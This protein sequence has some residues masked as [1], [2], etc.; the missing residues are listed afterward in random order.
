[1]YHLPNIC[2]FVPSY[3]E[4]ATSH[5]TAMLLAMTVIVDARMHTSFYSYK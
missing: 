5:R 3:R 2:W 4:I 1:M